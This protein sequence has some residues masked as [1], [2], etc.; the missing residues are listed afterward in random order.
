MKVQDQCRECARPAVVGMPP[1]GRLSVVIW[2]C[3][4]CSCGNV[5]AWDLQRDEPAGAELGEYG[6][7]PSDRGRE[8]L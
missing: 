4:V 3:K 2:R 5:T 6:R 7:F 1:G 8:S